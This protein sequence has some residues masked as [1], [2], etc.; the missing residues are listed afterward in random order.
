MTQQRAL[1]ATDFGLQ[2]TVTKPQQSSRALRH[3]LLTPGFDHMHRA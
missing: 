2:V 3:G 1:R